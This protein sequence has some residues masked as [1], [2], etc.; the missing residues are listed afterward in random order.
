M[1]DG[2]SVSNANND[3]VRKLRLYQKLLNAGK[4]ENLN[5]LMHQLILD[6]LICESVKGESSYLMATEYANWESKAEIRLG[7]A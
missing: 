6:D 1:P 4:K 3:V 2:T 5:T 7:L